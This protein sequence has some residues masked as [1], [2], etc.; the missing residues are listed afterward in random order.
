VK[1]F[2]RLKGKSQYG[3]AKK[4]LSAKDIF[5]WQVTDKEFPGRKL[6]EEKAA[7]LETFVG[8]WL[9]ADAI[10]CRLVEFY[11][12]TR[13]A[14]LLISE[15]PHVSKE[16]RRISTEGLH[17]STIDSYYSLYVPYRKSG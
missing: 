14:W 6:T 15:G 2:I 10:I 5:W 1:V 4:G 12:E 13:T 9:R 17:V 16:G 8:C 7:V 3:W 11:P